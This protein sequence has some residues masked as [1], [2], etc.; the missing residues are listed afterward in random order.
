MRTRLLA[1]LLGLA[2]AATA[3]VGGGRPAPP[4]RGKTKNDDPR[5]VRA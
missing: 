3:I 2:V 5:G 4:P 1:G